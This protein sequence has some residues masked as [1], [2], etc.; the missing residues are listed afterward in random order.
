MASTPSIFARRHYK[1]LAS[2]LG[3]VHMPASSVD[4]IIEA[5]HKENRNFKAV[6]FYQALG[7]DRDE[8]ERRANNL[9]RR[10]VT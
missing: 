7:Y 9:I 2:V 5:L 4:E 1:L 6:R 3:K 8:A 10:V